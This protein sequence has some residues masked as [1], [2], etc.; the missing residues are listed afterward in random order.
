VLN[1][2]VTPATIRSTICVQGWTATVRPPASYTDDLKRKQMAT[3][4]L[5]GTSADY[6]ED[7]R[8]PLELG[9]NPT[10]PQNLSPESRAP[11]PYSAASKDSGENQARQAVCE[12]NVPLRQAQ[13]DF[14]K[15]WLKPW[16]LYVT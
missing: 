16:P 2:D 8:M 3:E 14:V 15:K 1:P 9:G 13:A 6:E 10:D 5:T 4:H 7:H 12:Q 11:G